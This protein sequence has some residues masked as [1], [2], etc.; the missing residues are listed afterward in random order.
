MYISTVLRFLALLATTSA[1]VQ[2]TNYSSEEYILIEDG[3]AALYEDTG[4][5]YHVINLTYYRDILNNIKGK[6]TRLTKL[7]LRNLET[8]DRL[9][10]QLTIRNRSKRGI[11]EIGTLWKWISGSPDHD[12]KVRIETKLQELIE[13]NNKQYQTN[14]QIFKAIEKLAAE[15]N[16]IDK[17]DDLVLRLIIEDLREI[18]NAINLSKNE[19]L[20][21]VILNMNDLNKIIN[22]ETLPIS[23][24]D[25]LDASD[26]K[27][28]QNK[29]LILIYIEYPLVTEIN[30][31][32][33]VESINVGDGKLSLP[34]QVVL[35]KE[36]YKM[37]NCIKEL[38]DIYCRVN[39]ETNCLTNLLNNKKADCHKVKENNPEVKIIKDGIIFV[40]G[41]TTINE[42]VYIG[43]YLIHFK[44]NVTIN[45]K[46]YENKRTEILKHMK[47]NSPIELN[48]LKYLE[49]SDEKL[50]FSNIDLIRPYIKDM[51]EHP[52]LYGITLNIVLVLSIYI[53]IKLLKIYKL[54]Q[55]K[56][57]RKIFE[58]TSLK[59][60][61]ETRKA[62]EER[63][64][65]SLPG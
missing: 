18:I 43:I 14:S 2:I 53:V 29:D 39:N 44:N 21:T 34:N 47:L 54:R 8:A 65:R 41:K 17:E 64:G 10:E 28:I 50:K 32:Y 40:S 62:I 33:I 63:S 11:N 42:K 27:I 15:D 23:I 6:N 26:F 3:P 58:M 60:L 19:I 4:D 12:D 61:Q 9:L 36:K 30:K 16:E 55:E 38:N 24:A 13:S 20:N 35:Y 7:E 56:E 37:A 51:K 52:I 48:I 5:L 31:K 1:Q 57:N 59:C 49:S 22:T 46:R 25:V 45:S